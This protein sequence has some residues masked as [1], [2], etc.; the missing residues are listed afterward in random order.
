MH[1]ILV[2]TENELADSFFDVGIHNTILCK[3]AMAGLFMANHN[4]YFKI[5]VDINLKNIVWTEFMAIW[6]KVS[7][8]KKL[9][10]RDLSKLMS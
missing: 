9:I 4:K 6:E 1:N 2:I 5:I 10:I 7:A 3:D 8:G